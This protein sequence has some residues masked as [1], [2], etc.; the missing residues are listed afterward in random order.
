MR[1]NRSLKRH[2]GAGRNDK[3]TSVPV[4]RPEIF[5]RTALSRAAAAGVLGIVNA[6]VLTSAL[7][8]RLMNVQ[9]GWYAPVP[10]V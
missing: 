4:C 3:Q 2:M 7:Q 1:K 8:P 6:F 10:Q 9:M 5:I